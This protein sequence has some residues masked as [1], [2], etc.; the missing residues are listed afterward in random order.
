ML[1]SSA[2]QNV[3]DDNAAGFYMLMLTQTHVTGKR[4][5]KLALFCK[6]NGAGK[7]HYRN[8]HFVNR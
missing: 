1:P 2:G 7:V 4:A 6:V 3:Q 5:D 8:Q